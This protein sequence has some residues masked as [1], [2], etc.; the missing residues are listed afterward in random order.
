M[1]RRTSPQVAPHTT[2]VSWMIAGGTVAVALVVGILI[3]ASTG[4]P[5]ASGALFVAPLLFLVTL[6]FL[7]R[8]GKLDGD[9]GLYR[10]LVLALA[11]KF[12]GAVLRYYVAFDVYGG[13]ADAAGYHDWGVRI[14]ESFRAGIFDTGLDTLSDTNFIRFLTGVVY[15][16]FGDSSLGGF[17][18]FAWLGF[19]GQ[20]FFYRAFRIAVPEGKSRQYAAFIFFLPSLIFWPSSV[21]KEAWMTFALGIAALGA[22]RLM[23]GRF[24]KGFALV[25]VGMWLAALVRP[26]VA[27]LMG[28]ALAAGYLLRRPRKELGLFGPVAKAVGLAALAVVAF[29]LVARTDAFLERAAI[30]T[31]QGV[32]AVLRQTSERTE[33]GGSSFAPSI[34][35][36]PTRAPVAVVTVLFRPFLFEVHNV[37]ALAAAVETTIVLLL[38]IFRFR[39]ILAA[40]RSIRRQP[41]VALAVAYTGLFV[42][43]FSGFANFGLLARE[44]VQMLPFFLV[45]LCIPPAEDDVVAD[46]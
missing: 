9:R 34:L 43:A 26:H 15:S 16:V 42:L 44:R 3:F 21:G 2:G 25:G 29:L 1:A 36:S 17:F 24:G 37:P 33:T 5:D 14:A 45:L 10:L 6:P 28:L 38:C 40:L 41:Y 19:W 12:L 20:Y 32:A 35:E 7:S 8:R 11:V 30:D 39:W 23:V 4:T 27:G 13:V 22:A 46:R 18:V 31:D